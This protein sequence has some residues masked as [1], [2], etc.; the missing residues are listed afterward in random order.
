MSINGRSL[1]IGAVLALVAFFVP[2]LLVV[3]GGFYDV[4][5]DTPHWAVTRHLIGMARESSIER[6]SGEVK[7]PSLDDTRMI[8]DGAADYDA[9]CTACHLAP[10]MAE[11]EMRP[12][13]NPR[14]PVLWKIKG[15][16]PREEFWIIKHGIRMTGMPAWGVTHSDAEIWNM[17]AFLQKLPSLSPQQYHAIVAAGGNHHEHDHMDMH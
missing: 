11:N 10:G 1:L 7:V 17:V 5:A 14:P 6:R 15:E 16:D 9:M 3:L 13:L 12:G 2:A 8:S 4:G